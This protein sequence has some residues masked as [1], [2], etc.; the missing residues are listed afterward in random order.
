MNC[1][2]A[3]FIPLMIFCKNLQHKNS[4]GGKGRKWGEKG[5]GCCKFMFQKLNCYE[6]A[7]T[8][9]KYQNNLMQSTHSLNA[10]LS[11]FGKARNCREGWCCL[12]TCQS[13]HRPSSEG[14]GGVREEWISARHCIYL[15]IIIVKNRS[16][17]LKI[18]T[19]KVL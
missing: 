3:Y 17:F 11:S 10:H 8:Q 5:C 6:S 12:G 18:V 2:V 13:V 16:W 14:V 19:A 1:T 4:P 9:F 7:I 15:N